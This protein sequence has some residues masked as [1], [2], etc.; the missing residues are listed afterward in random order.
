MGSSRKNRAVPHIPAF[1]STGG[2]GAEKAFVTAKNM[3]HNMGLC[4]MKWLGGGGGVL[5]PIFFC[6]FRA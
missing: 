4:R 3:R 5:Y 6:G 2:V 1:Q